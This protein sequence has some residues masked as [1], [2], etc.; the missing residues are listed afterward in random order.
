[1][2][3]LTNEGLTGI[4]WHTLAPNLWCTVYSGIFQA[5]LCI[6]GSVVRG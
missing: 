4:G 5:V 2:W 6:W 1:M 3:C